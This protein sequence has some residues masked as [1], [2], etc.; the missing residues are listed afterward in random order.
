[1]D[2]PSLTI[3]H[4]LGKQA[5]LQGEG[6]M[7]KSLLRSRV[8]FP[9]IIICVACPNSFSYQFDGFLSDQTSQRLWVP[10]CIRCS[11]HDRKIPPRS[12]FG[13]NYMFGHVLA[14]KFGFLWTII[15]I[16]IPS[17]ID[18]Y[19][20]GCQLALFRAKFQKSGPFENG[21]AS[22]NLFG[23]FTKFGL[24]LALLKT[25]W[26]Q[27]NYCAELITELNLTWNR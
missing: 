3:L 17:P 2:C 18:R 21:L 19:E 8:G 25:D 9:S 11:I 15:G 12:P 5:K 13:P 26:P 20:Q 24:N 14:A 27:I 1:M 22:K 4:S 7:G 23:L 10:R 16:S 6:A